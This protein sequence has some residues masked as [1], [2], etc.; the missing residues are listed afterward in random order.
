MVVFK[1]RSGE[2]GTAEKMKKSMQWGCETA[3]NPSHRQQQNEY[4][5]W[6][7]AN[8]ELTAIGRNDLLA[9]ENGQ[10]RNRSASNA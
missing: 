7:D 2:L 9:G 10:G 6:A 5:A 4:V 1:E 8:V 3:R